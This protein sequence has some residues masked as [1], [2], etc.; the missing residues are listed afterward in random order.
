MF[1]SNSL[2]IKNSGILYLN[3]CWSELSV[4][5]Y[6]KLCCSVKSAVSVL[7][8]SMFTS[9]SLQRDLCGCYSKDSGVRLHFTV[10]TLVPWRTMAN[11][12][13]GLSVR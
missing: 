6:V 5:V 3:A 7:D 1:D 8:H 11:C 2:K 4:S 12:A 10:G 13:I 9:V